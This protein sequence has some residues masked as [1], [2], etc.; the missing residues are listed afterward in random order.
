M[1][2][3]GDESGFT[4]VE[5][6]VAMSLSLVVLG[7]SLDAFA[8]FDNRSRAANVQ[9]DAQANVRQSV[10]QL[11]R[12]L[13]NAV[14]SG[15]PTAVP[16]EKA[17]AYDVVFQTIDHTP[18][19]AGSSNKLN[20]KRVR[21]CLDSS[22]TSRERIWKQTQRWTSATVPASPSTASCP[23]TGWGAQVAAADRLV[24][25][26][27]GQIRP[28]FAFSYS[29]TSSTDLA[30]LAAVQ[31]SLFVD[32]EPGKRSGAAELTSAVRLRNSNRRPTALFTAT[33][34]NGHVLL[35]ASPSIDPEGQA[36]SYQWSIDGAAI[37]GATNARLDHRGLTSGTTHSFT[38]QVTDLGGLSDQKTLSVTIE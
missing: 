27:N 9:A 2:G 6:L 5:L 4:L 28:A 8:G 25:L 33:Q 18:V 26:Y 30:D 12:E 1:N 10:N 38:L 3:L 14:S 11:A 36:L 15:T 19:P 23:G 31:T 37:A 29:P 24:N 32:V 34:Q 35:N 22:D 20:L 13:R 21:Y 7:A 17:T 16:V